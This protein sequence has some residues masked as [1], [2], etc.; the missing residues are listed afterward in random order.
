MPMLPMFYNNLKTIVQTDDH[1]MI[2]V[3][4][5]HWARDHPAGRSAKPEHLPPE[6]RSLGGDSIGWWEG[7]TLV[8]DTTNFLEE[9]WQAA[10]LFGEPSPTAISTW[11][12]ASPASTAT[13]CST[14]S[15]STT[16]TTRRPTAASTPGRRPSGSS[17]STPATKATTRWA[18][19]CAARGCS[20]GKPPPAHRAVGGKGLALSPAARAAPRSA[21]STS[22]GRRL[23]VERGER[24]LDLARPR[25]IEPC[26]HWSLARRS[27]ALSRVDS[28][29]LPSVSRI[30]RLDS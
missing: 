29:G 12:S 24:Q 23:P 15:R 7:D 17:T 27:S 20:S 30:A 6:I 2:L 11:S 26:R 19:C 22:G 18:T 21:R 9:D 13:R 25:S 1:V 5:M 10:T 16:A 8:V 3:E 4:W 14:S 28:A